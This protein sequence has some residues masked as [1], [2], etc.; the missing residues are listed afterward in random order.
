MKAK[1]VKK[2]TEAKGTVSF[3]FEPERQT[4]FLPG[5]YYYFTLPKL[6]YPDSRGATRHFTI[7]SAPTESKIF[8]IT[9][10][11]REESGYKKTLNALPI[12]SVVEIEGPNGTLIFDES[13]MGKNHVFLAGGIGI[14][15][16]R[17]FIKYN[18]DRGLKIPM[19]LIY[20]NNNP[21]FVY[22]KE[23]DQ[24]AKE[25]DYIKIAYF[26]SSHSGHLDEVKINKFI[27]NWLAPSGAKLEIGNCTVWLVGPP[28][29]VDAVEVALEKLKI[30]SNQIRSEKFT[31]Y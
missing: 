16:F 31:G 2:T 23:L 21:E 28:P 1:L 17:S 9:T 26:D 22:K 30:K 25:N 18:V 13:E 3:F 19:F 12:G 14:T 10:R 27:G 29:F 6:D 15:P 24:I 8:Q 5:Q 20:S 7:A 11:I 4:S